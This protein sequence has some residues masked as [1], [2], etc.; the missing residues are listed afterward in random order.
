M[1]VKLLGLAFK[2]L[3]RPGTH[4]ITFPL[5]CVLATLAYFF[6]V[7]RPLCYSSETLRIWG[8]GARR[9]TCLFLKIIHSL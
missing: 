8:W 5:P 9:D 7:F 3:W 2:A 6:P 1:N 4:L